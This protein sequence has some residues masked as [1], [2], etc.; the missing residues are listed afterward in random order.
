MRLFSDDADRE[1]TPAVKKLK[2]LYLSFRAGI[3]RLLFK[4]ESIGTIDP[5]RID[6]ICVVRIDRIGDVV[7][8]LPAIQALA[9]IFP[10]SRIAVL[11][12]RQNCGLLKNI[13]GITPIPYKGFWDAVGVMRTAN[14]SMTIDLL[15]DYT[16]KTAMLA[17]V[18]R[19]KVRAGFDIGSRGLLFNCAVA[20]DSRQ[21]PMRTHLLD[22]VRV[23]AQHAGYDQQI[24]EEEPR[25]TISEDDRAFARDFLHLSG[26][27][28]KQSLIGI[29]PGGY[30]PSQQWM[31]ESFVQLSRRISARYNARII[32]FGSAGEKRS[33]ERIVSAIGPQAIAATGLPLH[34]CAALISVMDIMVCNNSGLVH[35]AAALG[36]RTVSTMG[37]TDPVLW[38][39]A[40]EK[41][42]VI[43][44]DE[45]CSPCGKPRCARHSCMTGI[46]VDEMEQA[47][48]Q[49]LDSR[50][51]GN[52]KM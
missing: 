8:S 30:F 38:Y 25:L 47:V 49:Q 16:L 45:A 6:S 12:R 48:V 11:A 9:K 15:R 46:S 35:I 41:S 21:R 51:R 24:P 32:V 42:V 52:D 7:V 28:E 13:P 36:I 19:A 26:G 3:L 37:P 17:Y 23:I 10:K 44:R 29:H 31:E 34:R 22:L 14:F 33:V 1:D 4:P 43:R 18:S 40:G 20:P 39:P 2:Q 50:L 27:K 5:N